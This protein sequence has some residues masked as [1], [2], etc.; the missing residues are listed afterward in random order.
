MV[1]CGTEDFRR[2]F[3]LRIAQS[4]VSC[5]VALCGSLCGATDV[6]EIGCCWLD[7]DSNGERQMQDWFEL[8]LGNDNR[9]EHP[10]WATQHEFG[11]L[12]PEV[13]KE[14]CHVREWPAGAA[15]RVIEAE[16][17]GDPD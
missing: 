16:D 14:G 10:L 11:G 15:L 5:P 13:L 1:R 12:T 4:R 8:I 6:R 2:A 17:D 7:F 9:V 3:E